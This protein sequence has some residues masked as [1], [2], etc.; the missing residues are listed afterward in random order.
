MDAY[1]AAFAIAGGDRLLTT[2]T[3]SRQF[4]GLELLSLSNG[5]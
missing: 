1:P 3:T 4:G 5:C 2:D